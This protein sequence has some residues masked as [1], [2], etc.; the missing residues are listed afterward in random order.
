M[1]DV[2]LIENLPFTTRRTIGSKARIG[3]VVLASDYTIEHEFRDVLRL[4][5][6][7]G[8]AL[9]QSRI[10]NA[11]SITPETLAAMGP[12]V[13]ETAERLLPGDDL[14][15]LAYGCTSASF[16]LGPGE[17]NTMLRAAKPAAA[18]TN[19]ASGTFAAL[20]AFGAKRIAVLTPYRSDV[21]AYVRRGLLNA[22]FE[23]PIFGSFNEEMDPVVA[24]IDAESLT[25]AL[26]LLTGKHKV[27]AA[28]VSCTSI[29]TIDAVA[30]LED[31]LGI[32]VT[33]SNHAI[34]WHCLRLAGYEGKP[35]GLGRL[36]KL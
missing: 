30:A 5:D 9:Y 16:V 20:K 34:T 22:D 12:T 2:E 19:P 35:D 29:R 23:V 13:T 8:I 3:L 15:V 33:S 25:G 26:R 7:P 11:P 10:A 27:D 32:P 21:N 18:T 36:F 1:A 28:F 4:T 6:E 31:E 14:D 17:V 24:D